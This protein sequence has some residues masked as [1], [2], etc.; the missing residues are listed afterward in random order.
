MGYLDD[1]FVQFYNEDADYYPGGQYF[2]N[3]LACWGYA[4]LQA[5]LTG[6]KS[7]RVNLGLAKGNIIPGIVGSSAVASRQG[8][9][10]QLPSP[11]NSSDPDAPYVYWYPQY[12]TAEP[13][14]YTGD[15][16]WPN[17]GVDKDPINITNA[18][19][20]ANT[21]L[22]VAL[23]NENIVATD[24]LSGMG[25]WAGGAATTMAEAVYNSGSALAPQGLPAIETYLWSDASYPAPNPNWSGNVPIQNI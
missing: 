1:V 16:G 19:V 20:A 21:L 5:Q 22:Q 11:P 10:P 18:I 14:N 9:T 15:G 3:L 4:V 25:F 6:P 8:P 23:G 13:P 24:W 12:A 17:T 7:P 2:A